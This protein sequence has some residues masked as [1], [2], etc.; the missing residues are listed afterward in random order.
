MTRIS[1]IES[2]ILMQ[3]NS[4]VIR[5]KWAVTDH[6]SQDLFHPI[7]TDNEVDNNL[8]YYL[9]ITNEKKQS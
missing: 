9:I 3:D 4:Q 2:A 1:T 8:N 5:A 7:G 6:S